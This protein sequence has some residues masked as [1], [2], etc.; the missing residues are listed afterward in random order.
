MG[1]LTGLLY[2]VLAVYLGGWYIGR[3]SGNF[4]LL[5]FVLTLVT[6]GY[7]LAERLQIGRAHV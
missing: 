3:W 4:S 7:W 6:F 5:L 1:S 2:G